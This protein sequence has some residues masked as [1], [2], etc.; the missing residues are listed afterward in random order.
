MKIKFSGSKAALIL[1]I[2]VLASG[3]SGQD[4]ANSTT[5][6]LMIHGAL[7]YIA[8]KK[9]NLGGSR[10][11]LILEIYSLI[12]LFWVGIMPVIAGVLYKINWYILHPLPL[13]VIIWSLIAYFW[14]LYK[15]D[16][17]KKSKED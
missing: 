6:F 17:V 1:G 10:K 11:W 3:V 15:G 5:G 9:Q 7:T 2:T 12:F 13:I 14:L 16:Q 8:R 4:H